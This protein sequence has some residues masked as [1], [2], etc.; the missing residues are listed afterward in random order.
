[1]SEWQ[2]TEYGTAPAT[3]N[4]LNIGD[5]SKIIT[6]GAHSSP[7]PQTTGMY[8]CS[9][10][11]MT[12]DRFDFSDC[13]LI[14]KDD[15]E[16][17]ITQGCKP[18]IGD[19]L[20]SKD[21]ANCLDLI[22]VHNQQEELVLLSS[23]AIVRLLPEVSPFFVRYFLLSPNCQ[24]TMRNNFVSGSAIPRVVLKDFKKVPVLLPP[25]AEQKAIA[26]VLSSLDDKIDL[27]HRQNKTLEAMA[28]TLFRQ[29]FMEDA[30]E[31][32][33]E[34]PV[35]SWGEVVCGKTPS[36][37]EAR[38]FGGDVP[39]IKIPDMH[40]QAFICQT[41]DSLTLEGRDS[42]P[43]KTIPAGAICV[44]CIATVGLVSITTTASQTNQQINSVIPKKDEY[45]YF[46]YLFMKSS[47]D[48]LHAMASGGTATLNLNTG[49][50]SNI[51]IP[52]PGEELLADFQ[53]IV[54][55]IFQKVS[56][57]QTQIRTLG[58]LRD[59][60]LPKLMSGEVRVAMDA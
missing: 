23:I 9:V 43:K 30:Q 8:M 40:G 21:G 11:D 13:K 25:Y 31:Y 35:S 19:I 3:W 47:Y 4:V 22:F 20:I 54:T 18:Q 38:Y 57:N 32:W 45:R 26:A 56:E 49:N 58:K 29:W 52:F 7:K 48:L 53:G 27:L 44:S 39:F 59:T 1:M 60:L 42:Q 51:A 5:I 41:E 55:P 37:A 2:E 15:Y 6:D 28:E 33:A 14:S 10:K 17:L 24:E 16:K 46:L 36:K 50:F 34:W 12:Y